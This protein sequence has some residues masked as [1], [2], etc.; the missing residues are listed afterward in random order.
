MEKSA[1]FFAIGVML[2]VCEAQL[3]FV[4][5]LYGREENS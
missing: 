2:L 5:S 1:V 3:A 4:L